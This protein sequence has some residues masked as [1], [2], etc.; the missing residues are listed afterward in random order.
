[1]EREDG[2]IGMKTGKTSAEGRFTNAVLG[3]FRIASGD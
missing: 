2:M 1:M 3:T